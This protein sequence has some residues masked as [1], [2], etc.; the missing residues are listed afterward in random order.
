VSPDDVRHAVEDFWFRRDSQTSQLEDGGRAGGAARANGHMGGF[1]QLVARAFIDHGIPPSCIKIGMPYLPGYYRVRKQWDLVVV[2]KQTLVAAVEF[3]SQV[4][5]VG[6][7]INN[8]FEEALGTATDTRAAQEKNMTYGDVPPWLGYVFVLQET[9]ET[10]LPNRS[11]KALFPTD[12]GFTGLSYN[13]RYQE[14]L[15]RFIGENVYQAGWLITTKRTDGS[16]TYLEPLATATAKSFVTA[17]EGRIAWV[18]SI[19]D[20]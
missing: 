13:Q 19:V 10:E 7:N 8:R 9:P 2:Y 12:P 6:K 4:G 20:R 18:K 3:K 11:T 15:R 5:S 14:M 1:T 17:I 16:V